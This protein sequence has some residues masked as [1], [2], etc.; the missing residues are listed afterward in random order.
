MSNEK[1]QAWRTGLLT[2][3]QRVLSD[4]WSGVP[5]EFRLSL[6]LMVG[7][8]KLHPKTTVRRMKANNLP[9]C[10]ALIAALDSGAASLFATTNS[11]ESASG[12]PGSPA[13]K[14]F[15][16]AVAKAPDEAR[17]QAWNW[18]VQN[19]DIVQGDPGFPAQYSGPNSLDSNGEV[20]ETVSLDLSRRGAPCGR[21]PRRTWMA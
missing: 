15:S 6:A 9:M 18:H 5:V 19:T 8:T 1:P 10:L 4:T 11:T 3:L 21:A 2:N 13:D 12:P 20:Q 7:M 14:P 17:E 16:E